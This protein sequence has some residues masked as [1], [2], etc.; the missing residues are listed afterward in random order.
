MFPK[1]LLKCKIERRCHENVVKTAKLNTSREQVTRVPCV[2]S[3]L[4][5][6]H[7][8]RAVRLPK[9][10]DRFRKRPTHGTIIARVNLNKKRRNFYL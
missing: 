5:Q 8:G 7:E 6:G 1:T 4:T 3:S 9:A 10:P 2:S